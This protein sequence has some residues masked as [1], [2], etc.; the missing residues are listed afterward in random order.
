MTASL[1]ALLQ[2]LCPA[3]ILCV[4]DDDVPA[5]EKYRLTKPDATVTSIDHSTPPTRELGRFD[6]TIVSSVLERLSKSEGIL[7]LANLRNFHSNVIAVTIP[8][9]EVEARTRWSDREFIALGL[10]PATSAPGD[11]GRLYVY[12]IKAYNRHRVWNNPRYWA[13]P[14]NFR[15]YRW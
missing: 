9:E 14:E 12:D 10:E 15:K 2:A 5:V 11:P 13:H 6:L 8:N 3:S 7:L 1:S 4:C